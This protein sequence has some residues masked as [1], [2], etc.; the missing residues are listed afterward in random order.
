ME[1]LLLPGDME[2]FGRDAARAQP[3]GQIEVEDGGLLLVRASRLG[4]QM[5]ASPLAASTLA[6][7]FVTVQPIQSSSDSCSLPGP[8]VFVITER[9]CTPSDGRTSC[10]RTLRQRF[11]KEVLRLAALAQNDEMGYPPYRLANC[12]PTAPVLILG[13]TLYMLGDDAVAFP[14]LEHSHRLNPGDAQT[15]AVLENLRAE[16]EKK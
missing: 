4:L 3:V 11:K 12:G 9:F 13:A 10:D 6:C 15:E 5:P 8:S 14:V 7:Q 16:R 2:R 1:V